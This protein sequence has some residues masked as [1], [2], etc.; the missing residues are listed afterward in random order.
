MILQ[1]N[2]EILITNRNVYRYK[3]QGYEV[4]V[5]QILLI[6]NESLPKNSRKQEQ[7]QC[8]DCR[9]ILTRSHRDCLVT[10]EKFGRDLCP[11]CANKARKEKVKIT[12]LKKYGV[13]YP[14]Q[15]EEIKKKAKETTRKNWRCDYS[16]QNKE[17]NKQAREAFEEKYGT[18]GVFNIL[19]FKE[20]VEKT[21][22]EKFGSKNCFGNKEI[23]EKIKETILKKYGCENI[24][25]SNV[26]KE[27]RENTCLE[28]YGVKHPL[29]HKE[30]LE[31]AQKTTFDRFGVISAAQNPEIRKKMT[32]TL[33]KNGNAPVSKQQQEIF[34][35]CKEEFADCEVFLN[36]PCSALL[37][38]VV[39]KT[40]QGQLYDIEYD[41][42][43]WHQDSQKDR[44][45]DEI[46]KKF[47]YKIIRIRA[48]RKIPEISQIKNAIDYIEENNRAFFLINL[49]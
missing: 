12:N 10:F 49:E 24:G 47:G 1:P 15:S 23:Q 33:L 45:R 46:V 19:E 40:P 9:E 3:K 35:K 21:N 22:L 39:I 32:Q 30:F 17:L 11:K 29:Q 7:R 28:R 6:K 27:K 42:I 25:Q 43:Y 8:D 31:K 44:R 13:E 20:K 36:R 41:G 5:G 48:E 38:D 37:L 2:I 34:E 14:M 4:E 26:I 16:L 18:N